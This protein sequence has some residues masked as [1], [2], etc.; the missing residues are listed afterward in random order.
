MMLTWGREARN[1]FE[2]QKEHHRKYSLPRLASFKSEINR[3]SIDFFVI[4]LKWCALRFF[5]TVQK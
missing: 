2:E 1:V 4:V 3:T 5:Q